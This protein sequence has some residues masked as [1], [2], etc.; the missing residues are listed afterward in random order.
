[1]ANIFIVGLAH[2]VQTTSG[3]CSSSQKEQY[4]KFITDVIG[5]YHID[6]VAEEWEPSNATRTIAQELVEPPSRWQPIDLSTE[7]KKRL[8]VPQFVPSSPQPPASDDGDSR[9]QIVDGGFQTHIAS[10]FVSVEWRTPQDAARDQH[11]FDRVIE[12]SGNHRNILVLCG[13]NHLT[14][15]AKKFRA[16][17]TSVKESDSLIEVLYGTENVRVRFPL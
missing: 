9:T 8:G 1:M 16:A 15:L 4:R 17:G 5:Q 6:F 13:F 14:Q 7:E 3:G 10:D 12:Q 11:M 2:G